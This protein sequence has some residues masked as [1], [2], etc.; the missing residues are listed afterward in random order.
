MDKVLQL[1]D[2]LAI[3][4]KSPDLPADVKSKDISSGSSG[5]V[6]DAF[7]NQGGTIVK[8]PQIY[9]VFIGDWSGITSKLRATNLDTFI[10]D[11]LTSDWMNVLAEYNDSLAGSKFMGSIFLPSPSDTLLGSDVQKLLI[12]AIKSKQLAEPIGNSSVYMVFLADGTSITDAALGVAMCQKNSD[13]AFGYH[14]MFTSAKS[15]TGYFSVI[16][17][18]NDACL[19]YTCLGGAGCSLSLSSNQE[20]RQT[21]VASHEL[22][23]TLTNPSGKAWYDNKSGDEIGDICNG[24][25]TTIKVGV[26]SWVVQ[27]MYSKKEDLA[28][29]GKTYCVGTASKITGKS[30]DPVVSSF[31][32]KSVII[33]TYAFG[34]ALLFYAIVKYI[35]HH[36]RKKV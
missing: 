12:S 22:A 4:A 35:I 20:Q 31:P 17:S 25:S 1:K 18:L 7:T 29:G 24:N 16:P 2:V 5:Q 8:S 10:Q 6:H 14:S 19:T 27:K 15:N 11:L 30:T 32:V 26:N 13:T 23:E 21:Q 34:G 36:T 9:N 28:T 33:G 3:A